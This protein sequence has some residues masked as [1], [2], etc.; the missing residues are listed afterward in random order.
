MSSLRQ[1]TSFPSELLNNPFQLFKRVES[2]HSQ[3]STRF[4]FFFNEHAW[5]VKIIE[6]EKGN[7]IH[8]TKD[9]WGT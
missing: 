2:S 6:K 5:A 8:Q 1:S 9:I 7:L 4:F 3:E